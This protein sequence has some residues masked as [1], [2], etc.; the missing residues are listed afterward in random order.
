MTDPELQLIMATLENHREDVRRDLDEMKQ[1]VKCEVGKHAGLVNAH[2]LRF[3]KMDAV[4]RAAAKV[5]TFG[6]MI[7][8]GLW[9]IITFAWGHR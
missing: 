5:L 4:G 7:A 9:A 2:E 6:S 1:Y 8:G 3:T